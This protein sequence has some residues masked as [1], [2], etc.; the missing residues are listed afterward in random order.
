LS[1]CDVVVTMGC[2]TLEL[3]ADVEV[4]D[5]ALDDPH[6]H[7]VERVR[8]IRNDIEKRVS[9]LFDEFVGGRD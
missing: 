4:R 6:G 8:E 2:S 7:P 5:W 3:N 9:A 1:E